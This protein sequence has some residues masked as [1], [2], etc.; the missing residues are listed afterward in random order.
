[1]CAHSVHLRLVSPC[2]KKKLKNSIA[3]KTF[4]TDRKPRS[5]SSNVLPFSRGGGSRTR[6]EIIQSS[7]QYLDR[8]SGSAGTRGNRTRRSMSVVAK[9]RKERKER[10]K[11][12]E[13][14][15]RTAVVRSNRWRF[16]P[17]VRFACTIHPSRFVSSVLDFSVKYSGAVARVAYFEAATI[18]THEVH[19]ISR[20]LLLPFCGPRLSVGDGTPRVSGFR[21]SRSNVAVTF[22]RVYG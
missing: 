7:I 17:F 12:K 18:S 4:P 2:A 13:R 14:K 11:V 19:R 9:E 22:R 21:S 5:S 15:H 6:E 8:S 1:M 20:E 10:K 16:F 3:R